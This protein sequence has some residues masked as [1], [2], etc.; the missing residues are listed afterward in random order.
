VADIS[1]VFALWIIVVDPYFLPSD[2]GSDLE[3]A[4]RYPRVCTCD[5][6]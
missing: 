1:L 6:L 4:G 5:E 2:S 3:G